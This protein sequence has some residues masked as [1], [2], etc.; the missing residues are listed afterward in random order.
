MTTPVARFDD[1]FESENA[2]SLFWPLQS[3]FSASE[4]YQF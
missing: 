4:H 1:I 2:I 3:H